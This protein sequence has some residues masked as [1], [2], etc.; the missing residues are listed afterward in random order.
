MSRKLPYLDLYTGDWL[1]D[2]AVSLCEPATRGIWIDLL[3]AM[4]ERDR[5]GVIAGTREQLARISRCSAVAL[6]HALADLQT[7]KAAEITERDGKV[8][9]INRRMKNAADKRR[10]DA[11]RQAQKRLSAECHSD[12]ALDNDIDL[13]EIEKKVS[14]LFER[15]WQVYP[16]GRK[17]S[18]GAAREAFTKAIGKESAEVIITAA[19][20]YAGTPEGKGKY[21]KMPSTWLNQECWDD[22]RAAWESKDI[23]PAEES[24]RKADEVRE[25][26][27]RIAAEQNAR[28]RADHERIAAERQRQAQEAIERTVKRP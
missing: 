13:K 8:T 28:I 1:K 22:D 3:C 4:H 17:K 5:C 16:S 14:E 24:R 12:V 27:R 18:K 15:F 10:R 19:R 25:Q 2:P 9:V 21:V 7:T 23:D 6:D 26:E 11:E 20:H